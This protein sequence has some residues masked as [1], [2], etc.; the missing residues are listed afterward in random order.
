L[1]GYVI[2]LRVMAYIISAD[3]IKETLP[4]YTPDRAEAFHITSAKMADK[5]Y[6]KALKERPEDRVILMSGGTA[7]GKSEYVSAYLVNNE[8]I[9]LD[10]TLPSLEGASIKIRSARKAGKSV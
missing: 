9:I 3:D 8:A 10:G 2:I 1:F 7:S 4:G 6:A 5:A